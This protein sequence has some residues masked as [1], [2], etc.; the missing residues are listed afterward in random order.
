MVWPGGMQGAVVLKKTESLL[1]VRHFGASSSQKKGFENLYICY[2][3]C[4]F[5]HDS[6]LH[7]FQ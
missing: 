1:L 5:F 3:L 2:I 6:H 4:I 7:L